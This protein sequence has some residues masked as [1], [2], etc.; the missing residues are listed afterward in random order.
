MPNDKLGCFVALDGDDVGVT[1]EKLILRGDLAT[2]RSFS[3][4]MNRTMQTIK[5]G[6]ER[7]GATI[8]FCG[9]DSI[10]AEF[11]RETVD[12]QWIHDLAGR[13]CTFSVGVGCSPVSAYLALRMAK[14]LGKNQTISYEH[15]C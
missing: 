4:Q 3:E 9:G 7:L 13:P 2:A 15:L 8:V 12:A 10:L 11:S 14:G 5:Q 6:L 1:L